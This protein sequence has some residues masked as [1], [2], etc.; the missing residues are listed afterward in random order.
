MRVVGM[1][2]YYLF[3]NDTRHVQHLAGPEQPYLDSTNQ[4]RAC[5]VNSSCSY[6]TCFVSCLAR[7]QPSRQH[8]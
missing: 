5:A 6:D 8:T 4:F 3:D 1:D 2:N 7:V